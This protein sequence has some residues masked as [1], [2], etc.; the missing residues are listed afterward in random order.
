MDTPPDIRSAIAD[1]TYPASAADL[2]AHAEA[3]GAD[4][5][6]VAAL[7]SLPGIMTFSSPTEVAMRIRE[8]HADVA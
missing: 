7:R 3:G 8:S 6:V 2:A 5:E 4:E 1:A